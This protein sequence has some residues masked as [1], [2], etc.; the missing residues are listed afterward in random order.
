MPRVPD[1]VQARQRAVMDPKQRML[2]FSVGLTNDATSSARPLGSEF[3]RKTLTS[4]TP[5]SVQASVHTS[6]GTSQTSGSDVTSSSSKGVKRKRFEQLDSDAPVKASLSL[7][8]NKV[9]LQLTF[10]SLVSTI[11]FDQICEKRMT[12]F[13]A[14]KRQVV[15]A[16][17]ENISLH[18]AAKRLKTLPGYEKITPQQLSRWSTSKPKQNT[19]PKTSSS[20]EKAV[21]DELLV[22]GREEAVLVA[23]V[24]HS[25]HIIVRAAR[26]IQERAEYR[27]DLRVKHLKFTKPW[28]KG[29]LRRQAL[30]R[31]RVTASKKVLPPPEEVNARM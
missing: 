4:G 12:Y 15:A 21:L 1:L 7:G 16:I 13:N 19:R 2:T 3:V 23:N 8:C 5:P 31:R 10:R 24:T 25:Y 29:W 30:R 27:E 18:Q 20:F 17:P 22:N 28:V 9:K 14:Q 11:D 6:S 26:K